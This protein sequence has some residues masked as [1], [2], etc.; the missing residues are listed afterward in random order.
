MTVFLFL[1]FICYGRYFGMRTELT[2]IQKKVVIMGTKGSGK[3]TL[4]MQLQ[5]KPFKDDYG[6]TY[7][8]AVE[9]FNFTTKSG[10]TVKVAKTKDYGGGNEFVPYFKE[11]LEDGTF[12]IL[13]VDLA[14][15]TDAA[16]HQTLATLYLIR[17]TLNNFKSK[18]SGIK[19]IG[20]NFNKFSG[21]YKS[22][23]VAKTELI[24]F[25]GAEK[26]K[27]YSIKSLEVFELR[28]NTDIEKIKEEI[29]NS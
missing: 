21:D 25:L 2:K 4:W 16:K 28:D 26:I 10:R 8:E 3:T 12:V 9:A 5:G 22:K 7:S 23:E 13:L 15:L 27:R 17:N 19:V 6:Q 11:L 20:T 29:A 24:K 1:L 14:N 18:G